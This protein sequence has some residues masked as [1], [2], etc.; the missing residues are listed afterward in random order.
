[1]TEMMEEPHIYEDES[2]NRRVDVS[3]IRAKM[4]AIKWQASK[5]QPKKYG[6]QYIRADNVTI[7]DK[8]TH[9]DIA[10]RLAKLDDD[11]KKDH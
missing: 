8:E 4:D 5:L 1:M 10:Q 3:M 7:S 2:G 6:D 11:N 9:D